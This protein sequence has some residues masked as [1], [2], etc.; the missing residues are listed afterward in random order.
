MKNSA[1]KIIIFSVLLCCLA[2]QPLSAQ[3]FGKNKVNYDKFDWRIYKSAHFDVYYYPEEEAF[4]DDMV[5]WAETGYK[6]LSKK[7]NYELSQRT[8]LIFF[9][10]HG[11]FEQ[12]NIVPIFMPEGVGAFAEPVRNRMVIPLDDPPEKMY[13]LV[14][15]EM[16]HIFQFD[17]FF[18]SNLVNRIRSNPPLWLTEGMAE[19]MAENLTTMDEMIARDLIVNDLIPPLDRLS[20][21]HPIASYIIG[22]LIWDFIEDKWGEEGVRSFIWELRKNG[23]NYGGIKR[24]LKEVFNL[25][26]EEFYNE[27]RRSLRKKYLP[28]LVK[29]KEPIDY[30]KSITPED[31]SYPIFSPV[32]SPS[33]ELIAALTIQKDDLDL[34]IFSAKDGKIIKNLTPGFS[35]DYE[36]II[37]EQLTVGFNGGRDI[38]WSADGVQIAF[39]GRSG[40]MRSLFVVDITTDKII[41]EVK[42]DIDQALSPALS[43]DGK[44]VALSGS[45]NGIR[46][47]F[48][49]ELSDY[50]I[51]NLTND[52]F[53]D[54]SPTFSPDGKVIIYTSSVKGK[55]KLFSLNVDEPETTKMQL[56]YGDYD[57]IQPIFSSNGEKVFFSSDENGIFNVYSLDLKSKLVAQYTDLLGGAFSPAP[58]GEK[59][60]TIVYTSYHKGAYKLYEMALEEPVRTY[61]VVP[62]PETE[63]EAISSFQPSLTFTLEEENKEKQAKH[64]FFVE[65]VQ[66]QGGVASNGT[67]L[68]YSV[69]SFSDMLGDNRFI[70]SFNTIGSL[71]RNVGF[72]YY[73]MKNRWNYGFSVYDQKIFFFNSIFQPDI[74]N[75]ILERLTIEYLGGSIF[76]SYPL[77]KF[78]RIELSA[79]FVKRAFE[80]P[81]YFYTK[82]ADAVLRERLEKNYQGGK[83]VSLGV[84]FV[85][86]TTRYKFFGPLSGRK[87]RFSFD[88]AP[89]FSDNFLSMYNLG[90]EFRNYTRIS[91]RSLLAFRF[92][93]AMSLGEARDVF[94][95][96]GTNTLRGY[97]YLEFSGTRAFFINSELRFPLVDQIKFPIGF[98][99][100]SIR[101]SFFFDIGAAWFEGE[102]FNFF[103]PGEGRKL[104]DAK[105]AFGLGVS[106]YLFNY[107]ELHWDFARRTDLVS[108]EPGWKVSFW[109]GNKF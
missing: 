9:K 57:D 49:V 70:F 12:Q 76:T 52:E 84:A 42:L 60:E 91:A 45:R 25:T 107:F 67:V 37:G 13:K 30:G 39:L 101:G 54:Y 16:T 48:V 27:L 31:F 62:Q 109:I 53:F 77:N 38:S 81:A 71:Y 103:A 73:S 55:T 11:E 35:G 102:E 95:F 58:L 86:D 87:Y 47:I 36:Y 4:L 33:G 69:I 75:V 1:Y 24:S 61:T 29:K 5:Y 106:F 2:L 74:S 98:S 50:S 90:T 19:H 14:V 105:A 20:P 96:G 63:E 80:L 64:K 78:Q 26:D 22:Q 82:E 28:L 46:D 72:T 7:L 93:G 108:I 3:Y 21:T 99:I 15:H 18:Q 89:P 23:P 34:V 8:P 32:V 104:E 41:H 100:D 43:A 79:N 66:A 92:Y 94:Y 10:T 40:K 6:Y 65:N 83:Y 56:T 51:K 17:I 44:R 68:T 85:G 59:E 88:Y 97:S